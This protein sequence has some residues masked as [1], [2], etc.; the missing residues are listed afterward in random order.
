VCEG[1]AVIQSERRGDERDIPDPFRP[2]A[3]AAG[4]R[5]GERET[6]VGP[7]EGPRDLPTLP[8]E[9]YDE[10]LADRCGGRLVHDL[11][12]HDLRGERGRRGDR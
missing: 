8:V 1:L 10:P 5:C 12:R 6:P 7:R 2:E 11:A 3:V 4:P 9:E